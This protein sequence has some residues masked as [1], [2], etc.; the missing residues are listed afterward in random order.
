MSYRGFSETYRSGRTRSRVAVALLAVTGV[1]LLLSALHD[2]RG[3]D[4]I[5]DAEAGTLSDSDA[6][7]YDQAT[8]VYASLYLVAFVATAIA[9]LAWLSR[10]VDNVPKLTTELPEVTPRWSIGWWFVPIANLL[11]PYQI[12]RNVNSL[13]ST[14]TSTGNALIFAWWIAWLVAGVGGAIVSRLPEPATLND[15]N[16][17]FT[18]NLVLDLTTVLAAG[19][20]ILVV[21]QI[22]SRADSRAAGLATKT[23]PASAS[24]ARGSQ[25]LPPCPRC[26]SAREAGVQFCGTCG[27]DLWDAYD[28]ERRGSR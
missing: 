10:T 5:R 7:L 9:Y 28:A 22:Q 4:L 21:R 3:F 23:V 6:T 19:L 13:L 27:L 25:T 24:T 8:Q 14:E 2:I 11:K 1:I 20:A 18:A 12:V 17:W 26:G 15:L 16:T